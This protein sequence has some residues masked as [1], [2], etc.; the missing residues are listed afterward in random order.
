MT[1]A[2]KS[3]FP[4]A[5]LKK[6]HHQPIS[7]P[8]QHDQLLRVHILKKELEKLAS[9]NFQ[10]MHVQLN[11]IQLNIIAEMHSK[12]MDGWLARITRLLTK[13]QQAGEIRNTLNVEL[14]AKAVWVYSTGVG[15]MGLLH[16]DSLPPEIQKQLISVYLDKLR[17]V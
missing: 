2:R 8:N 7:E 3:G 14:E 1:F 9:S 15:Q 4:V 11:F 17:L 12:L 13:A 10:F 6:S 5:G 16:P